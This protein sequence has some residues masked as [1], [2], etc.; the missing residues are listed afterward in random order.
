VSAWIRFA[1]ER[2]AAQDAKSVAGTYTIVS[3]KAFGD[4]PR[5]QMTLG[6]DGRYSLIL[7]RTTLPKVASG[8]R[9]T[10][11]AEE[12]KAVVGGSIAHFGKYTVDAKDKTITFKVA[13]ST[14]PNWDGATFK[15]PFKVSADQLSYTNSAP[16]SGGGATEV[17]WK[18]IK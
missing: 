3:V 2:A 13:T 5:G 1:P 17:V 9:D 4:N 18:R 16:S 8:V 15:R 6:H 10:G 11:T 12:N 7:A 14:F